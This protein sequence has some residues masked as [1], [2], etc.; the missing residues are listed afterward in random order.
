VLYRRFRQEAQ[1]ISRLEHPHIVPV[2]DFGQQGGVPYLVMRYIQCATVREL[3]AHGPQ[4]VAAVAVIISAVASGLDYAHQRG[5]LHRDVKPSNILLDPHGHAYLADFGLAKVLEASVTLTGSSGLMGTPA[6]MAPELHLG[7]P[8]SPQTDVYSLGVMM[9]ELVTGH[10]PYPADNPVAV[11][12]RHVNDPVPSPRQLQPDLPATVDHVIRRAMAKD[13]GDRYPD[14]GS[15]ARE[16]ASAG[17]P[18]GVAGFIDLVRSVAVVKSS[19]EVTQEVRRDV[20]RHISRYWRQMAVRWGSVAIAPLAL[21]YAL[22]SSANPPPPVAQTLT[23]NAR[24]STAIVATITSFFSTAT[25]IGPVQT[26][27]QAFFETL[28]A[29]DPGVRPTLFAFQTQALAEQRRA[30]AT[31][32]SL[33]RAVAPSAPTTR[34]TSTPPPPTTT[35]RASSTAMRA[36]PTRTATARP[37]TGTP[38]PPLTAGSQTPTHEP[39]V[40]T[41]SP[42]PEARQ[43][44]SL[45]PLV[46]PTTAA[47]G[48]ATDTPITPTATDTPITPTATDTPITP[49][50]T[51]TPITPTRTNSPRPPTKTN[52]PLPPPTA[53]PTRDLAASA[54]SAAQ[55]RTAIALTREALT[56]TPLPRPPR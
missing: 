25:A 12:F 6:Y 27:T 29:R 40:T 23:A 20:Q 44:P 13:P 41:V 21:A 7:Q 53:T 39:L 4:P 56:Q 16:L 37:A 30:Q 36:T 17:S 52:T 55:T 34:A 14:A 31:I 22:W 38:P 33:I 47:P 8:A 19:E 28:A 3:L 32:D 46:T 2:Y 10:L 43:T 15:L 45:T 11:A 54:T 49:T 9:F 51:D 50:A 1:I 48:T 24:T 18:A 26:K 5:I 35:A 42:T